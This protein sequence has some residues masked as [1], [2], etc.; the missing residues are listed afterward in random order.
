[1]EKIEAAARLLNDSMYGMETT[2]NCPILKAKTAYTAP[3]FNSEGSNL[4]GRKGS[5]IWI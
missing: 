5:E 1:M 2:T 4:S 3:F